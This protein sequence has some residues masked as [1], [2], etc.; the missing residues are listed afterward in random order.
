MKATETHRVQYGNSTIAFTLQYSDRKTLGM[1]VHPDSRVVVKAPHNT[2]LETIIT[3]VTQRGR[4]IT[5]Q[6]KQFAQYAPTL[7]AFEYVAGESYGY[8]GRQYRLEIIENKQEKIRLWQGKLEVSIP[9]PENRKQIENLVKRWYREKAQQI[10]LERYKH[11]TQIVTQQGITHQ[12]GFEL[13]TMEKRWGSCTKEGK[14]ILNPMLVIAP[15]DCIDYVIIHE[16]CHILIYNHSPSF[17]QLLATI[18][19]DWQKRQ[20]YLNN[21]ISLHKGSTC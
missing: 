13:R 9:N 19:P 10:Y 20:D 1:E 8:L 18:I 14:I 15:K 12:G 17:Y 3:R 21:H 4:W 7:P 5:K 11:C 16:L 6:Q 2:P